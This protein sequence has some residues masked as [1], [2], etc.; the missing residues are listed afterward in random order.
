MD[1][2]SD[3]ESSERSKLVGERVRHVVVLARS[4]PGWTRWASW[5]LS[6]VLALVAADVIVER[7]LAE[8]PLPKKLKVASSSQVYD[9]HGDL[10]ATYR[11]EIARFIIDTGELPG[12]VREAVIAAEDRDFY[13]HEG[14]S[15]TGTLRAAWRNLTSGEVEQGGSTITQQYIKNAVLKDSER[16]I[17]RKAKEAVLAIKLER[18]YSKDEIL[19][20]YMN[21]VYFG[22]GAY[23]IEAAARTYFGKRAAKLSLAEAAYLAGVIPS[24]ESYHPDENRQRAIERRNYVLGAMEEEGYISDEERDRA[25]GRKL[26]TSTSPE[27]RRRHQKA[28]FFLEWLRKDFLYPHFGDCLYTCGLKIH[29]TLDM[30]MQKAAERAIAETLTERDQPQA[31]LVSMTPRGSVRALVGGRRFTSIPDARGFNYATDGVRHAGSAFKPFTLLEAI[32]QDISPGSY[33][34]GESP[35]IIEDPMCAGPD[36][37]WMPENFGG[38]SYGTMTLDEGTMNSVNTVYAELITEVGPES[39]ADLLERFGFAASAEDGEIPPN[40]S[41]SLGAWDVSVLEMARAYAAIAGR[42]RLPEVTPITRVTDRSGKCLLGF[43]D[44]KEMKCKDE[45]DTG[46]KQVVEANSVDVMTQTLTGVVEAGTGTG[47]QIGRPV[48]G[49]TGT[50]QD[51]RDAWFA[52]YV[53]QLATVVWMGYP[54]EEG[55]DHQLGTGDDISPLMTY[56]EDPVTCR[57]VAGIEVTGGSFPASMWATFMSSALEDVEILDFSYPAYEPS[58]ILNPPPPPEPP[59]EEDAEDKEGD[60]EE[61][62]DDKENEGHGPPGDDKGKGKD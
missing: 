46:G 54:V 24:P 52:G 37:I 7:S 13:G 12:H 25:A 6:V 45:I 21:T 39:V 2:N 18:T 14:I 41:L 27:L 40:C 28:A 9:R 20:R 35:K 23:G 29:T 10:I 26:R 60:D 42:G 19:D 58:I 1:T 56:C 34:S 16:T 49:K 55:R 32:E 61:G 11:D 17:E 51:S 8:V 33:F 36:G 57:P 50:A 62:D 43:G 30:D 48:A 47:A 31:A 15:V 38:A 53:P 3:Q 59:A 44:P 5:G 4:L 22:R